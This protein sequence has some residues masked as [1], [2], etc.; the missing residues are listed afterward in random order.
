MCDVNIRI[1]MVILATHVDQSGCFV[2]SSPHVVGL[3]PEVYQTDIECTN[4]IGPNRI[5]LP[6]QK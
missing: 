4:I 2:K 5:R 1:T 6:K 3:D